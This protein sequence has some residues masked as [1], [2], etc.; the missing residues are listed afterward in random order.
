MKKQEVKVLQNGYLMLPKARVNYPRVVTRIGKDEE[1]DAGHFSV[2]L[3]WNTE[4]VDLSVLEKAIE[5]AAKD[6]G[7]KKGYRN[8]LRDGEEREGD[9]GYGEGIVFANVKAYKV[10]PRVVWADKSPVESDDDIIPGSYVRA[11]VSTFGY[12]KNKGKGVSIM[13]HALQCLGGGTRLISSVGGQNSVLADN[14]FDKVEAEETEEPD[15][16]EL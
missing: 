9:D 6:E 7:L 8:P 14:E 11:I 2:Q 10:P 12:N 15:D 13:L 5:K 16:D 1:I 4:K 3:I